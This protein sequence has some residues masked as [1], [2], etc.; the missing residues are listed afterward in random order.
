MQMNASGKNIL[1]KTLFGFLLTLSLFSFTHAQEVDAFKLYGW[2]ESLDGDWVLSSAEKQIGTDSYKHE[3]VAPLVG[4]SATGIAFKS[5]GRN[6]T[7]Q[8]DLLPNTPK[9][10]VTM[11]HCKEIWNVIKSRLHTTMSNKI[12]QSS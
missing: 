12:S 6:S 9:Q 10:M 3:A 1:Q 5:I 8:E 7:I 4:T 2:M 11:Y